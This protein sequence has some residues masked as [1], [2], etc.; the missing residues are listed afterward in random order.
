MKREHQP[1]FHDLGNQRPP[2][3]IYDQGAPLGIATGYASQE[4]ADQ[5]ED[6]LTPVPEDKDVAD[7]CGDERHV[8][9]ESADVIASKLGPDVLHMR[10]EGFASV[11]GGPVGK[12]LA[13]TAAELSML[14]DDES[15]RTYLKRAVA[16]GGLDGA[17]AEIR[18][19][20]GA[21]SVLHSDEHKEG[22]SPHFDAERNNDE[23]GCLYNGS[24]GMVLD[25]LANNQ[26]VRETALRDM[27]HVFQDSLDEESLQLLHTYNFML[28]QLGSAAK[29]YAFGRK[30]YAHAEAAGTPV[31]I[32]EGSHNPIEQNALAMNFN[33][34]RVG[35]TRM[36]IFRS[37]VG[38]IALGISPL[39]ADK[40]ISSSRFMKSTAILSVAVR[41][42]LAAADKNPHYNGKILPQN[43]PIAVIG[44]AAE[45]ARI[46]DDK[47]KIRSALARAVIL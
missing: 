26:A 7:S 19:V 8:A 21:K 17:L 22:G 4:T 37:D 11:F 23:V 12:A 31:V 25:T 27:R 28:K 10:D 30:A 29:R 38:R 32:L 18:A 16:N 3:S 13:V 42:A 33:L 14:P 36:G 41:G 46:I 1:Q 6:Q 35:N 15:K 34:D 9:R 47:A 24:L 43:L 45:A 20:R 40:H 39:L 5:F 44:S 2:V